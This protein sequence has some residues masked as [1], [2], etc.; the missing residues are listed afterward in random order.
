M[1]NTS[2][3]VATCTQHYCWGTQQIVKWQN[4]L[5]IILFSEEVFP[6]TFRKKFFRKVSGKKHLPEEEFVN[7]GSTHKLL[8]EEPSSGS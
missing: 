4:C 5:S 7:S 1:A 6:E 3:G 8:P 2:W